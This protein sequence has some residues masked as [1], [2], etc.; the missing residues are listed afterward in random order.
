MIHVFG[1]PLLGPLHGTALQQSCN[2]IFIPQ[3]GHVGNQKTLSERQSEREVGSVH[4]LCYRDKS[5]VDQKKL[6]IQKHYVFA[7]IMQKRAQS[8]L[9]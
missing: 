2:I 8:I 1:V 3:S 7:G 5:D 9:L 4:Q 6:G